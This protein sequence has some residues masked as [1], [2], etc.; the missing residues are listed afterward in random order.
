MLSYSCP[1]C[2]T[3]LK[4]PEADAG[5]RI[6][7]SHCQQR[8]EV[9]APKKQTRLG[10]LS[11]NSPA[12]PTAVLAPWL[13]PRTTSAR[14]KHW[15]RGARILMLAYLGLIVV[16]MVLGRSDPRTGQALAT[17][18]L[19]FLIC[20]WVLGHL[21]DDVSRRVAPDHVTGI[22]LLILFFGPLAWAVWMACRPPLR[23]A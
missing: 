10:I 2:G 15:Q 3:L 7:C 13:S 21:V 23:K 22:L 16:G 18:G 5:K 12:P 4:S 19:F 1:T 9:P 11:G 14:S 8:V 17:I 20:A 6:E